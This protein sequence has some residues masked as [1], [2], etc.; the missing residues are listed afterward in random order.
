MCVVLGQNL[1]L[2]Q[3]FQP[4]FNTTYLQFLSSHVSAITQG[5]GN[6]SAN[7]SSL[8]MF[9]MGWKVIAI[10]WHEF[11]TLGHRKYVWQGQDNCLRHPK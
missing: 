2:L 6:T 8:R 7:T 3:P 4:H 5:S 10:Q 9:I 1:M 11:W